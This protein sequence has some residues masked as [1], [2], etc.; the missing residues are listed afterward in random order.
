VAEITE[1]GPASLYQG[2]SLHRP[3]GSHL[4]L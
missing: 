4:Y 3:D 2:E 1:R